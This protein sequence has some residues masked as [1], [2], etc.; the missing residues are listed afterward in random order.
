MKAL[1]VGSTGADVERWQFFLRGGG[2]YF[3]EVDG[4]YGE[5]TKDSTED[6]QRRHG[7]TEDGIA[8]NRTIG[9]AM[10][11][12]FDVASADAADPGEQEFPPRPSFPRLDQQGREALLGKYPFRPAPVPDNPEAIQI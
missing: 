6:F 11:L 10:R 7:L 1:R 3:G 12:G 4:V 5:K 9:Q 8:G 2:L